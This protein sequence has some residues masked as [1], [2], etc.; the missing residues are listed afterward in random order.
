MGR[1]LDTCL[2]RESK[3]FPRFENRLE[4][5]GEVLPVLY[6]PRLSAEIVC[7][8]DQVPTSPGNVEGT[9]FPNYTQ[10]ELLFGRLP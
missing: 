10:S 3:S 6:L 1:R 9:S 4:S 5:I 8:K 7:E 2:F